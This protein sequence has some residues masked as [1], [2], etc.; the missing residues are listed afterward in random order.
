MSSHS[1][2]GRRSSPAPHLLLCSQWSIKQVKYSHA[3]DHASANEARAA[4]VPWCG[5]TGRC[6]SGSGIGRGCLS[7]GGHGSGGGCLI[8]VVVVA[9]PVS[10]GGGP[11]VLLTMLVPMNQKLLSP[12]VVGLG[13]VGQA[14]EVAEV[15]SVMVVMKVGVWLWW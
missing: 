7:G 12:A 6:W 3:S 13:D 9:A 1:S 4:V 8:M 2:S 14:L 15:G 5:W 11:L 10:I